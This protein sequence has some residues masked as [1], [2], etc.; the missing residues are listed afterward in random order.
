MHIWNSLDQV[1]S[2]FGPSVVTLGN[3]DG[4][5]RGHQQVLGQVRDIAARRNAKSV[6]LTFDPHP[7]LVHRPDSA[8][9]QIMGLA[10]KLAAMEGIGLDA[11]LVI[12]YTLEFAAQ[13]PEEF[14][15]NVFVDTLGACTVV[16]GHD[17]RFGKSNT[18]DLTTM[19]TLGAQLG[20]D[21]VVIDD[22]GHDRRWSSTWVREALDKGDVDTAAQVLG[23][24]HSMSGEVVHGAARGRV[25]GFPTANLSP[26]ACGSIPADGVYAGWLNDELGHRW[27][28]AISVGSNP[29]FE[30]VNRQVEAFVI[31]RPEEPIEAFNLYGQHVVVEF[32]KRLRGMVAYTGPEALI[33]Q[34]HKDVRESRNIL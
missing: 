2:G 8:P 4:L 3:F 32:V 1:P 34:M 28:A 29:T 16:V 22:E 21:V 18:G 5:H 26:D 12:P 31:G 11:V 9:G 33:E 7:A 24:W 27:P 6:A 25:L 17:V 20:F 14:V 13:T 23:R 30:G 15:R 19:V 10:D